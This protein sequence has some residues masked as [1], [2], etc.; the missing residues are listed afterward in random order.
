MKL[1]DRLKRLEAHAL[2]GRYIVVNTGFESIP[3]QQWGQRPI[4][5]EEGARRL[6]EA[7]R[8]AGPNDTVIVV[9]Y[10]DRWRDDTL[11]LEGILED[12]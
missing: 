1:A 4:S 8:A 5:R 2:P 9:E 12:S 11:G 10:T 6:A 7:Q 3:G